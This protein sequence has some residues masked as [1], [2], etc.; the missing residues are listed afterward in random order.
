MGLGSP[1][2][3]RMPLQ[4]RNAKMHRKLTK[5]IHTS[6]TFVVGLLD[7]D[8]N[9]ILFYQHERGR[10]NYNLRVLRLRPWNVVVQF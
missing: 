2:S 7:H 10:Q 1:T 8:A 9:M 5:H 3:K 6:E 4:M